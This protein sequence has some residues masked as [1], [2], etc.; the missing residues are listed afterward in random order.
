MYIPTNKEIIDAINEYT[1][2]ERYASKT[3]VTEES[4]AITGI[5]LNLKK[6]LIDI[7]CKISV[8]KKYNDN[9]SISDLEKSIV[10]NG[11]YESIIIDLYG[12][13]ENAKYEQ[14][15]EVNLSLILNTREVVLAKERLRSVRNFIGHSIYLGKNAR[16]YN[17]D[18]SILSIVEIIEIL[19][20][21]YRNMDYYLGVKYCEQNNFLSYNI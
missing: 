3:Y 11:L 2:A 4:I 6:I 10:L 12:T 7:P 5:M 18:I 15:K 1:T 19:Y 20:V 8:Y 17:F 16:R 9:N 21:L 14:N 13:I